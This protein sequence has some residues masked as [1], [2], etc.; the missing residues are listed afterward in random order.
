M[1]DRAALTLLWVVCGLIL[2]AAALA[3]PHGVLV[4]G[5]AVAVSSIRIAQAGLGVASLAA[6][7]YLIRFSKG[8]H[9]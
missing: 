9:A 5:Q 8:P 3:A 7:T 4:V 2:A 1:T 6:I